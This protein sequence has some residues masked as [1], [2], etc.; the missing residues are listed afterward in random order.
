MKTDA[1]IRYT[2]KVIQDAFLDIL[3]EKPVT[4]ITVKEICDQAEINRG[5]FYKHYRDCYDLLNK[6][7]EDGLREFEKM[8]AS[9]QATGT[10]TAVEAILYALR[11]NSQ[12]I[13]GL[14]KSTDGQRFVSRLAGSCFLYMEQWLGP[15]PPNTPSPT[16]RDASF[17]F[18][19]GGSSSVI[20]WWLRSGMKEPPEEIAALIVTCSERVV[21]G[22]SS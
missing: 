17:A 16:K 18:L 15:V 22:L 11:K 2:R 10:Q 5:T 4:K 14:D 9:I 6:I 3:K 7:E 21:A 20:E 19:A 13:Q 1:R 12:L 8:L